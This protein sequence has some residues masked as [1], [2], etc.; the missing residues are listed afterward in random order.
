MNLEKLNFLISAIRHN[1]TLRQKFAR[2]SHALFFLLYFPEYITYPTAE[3][4]REMFKLTEEKNKDLCVLSAFRGSAK[5]TIF[6][7]SLPIWKIISGQSHFVVIASQTQ[8]Q[9]R[10]HMSNIKKPLRPIGYYAMT[11][12]LLRWKI[13]SGDLPRDSSLSSMMPSSWSYP[14]SKPLEG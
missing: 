6:S 1:K 9:S 14:P 3:F 10:Q 4:Q 2:R 13:T 8:H 12:D 7:T 5:S 11:S